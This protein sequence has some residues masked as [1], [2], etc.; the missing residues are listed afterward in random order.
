MWIVEQRNSFL[1][2]SRY[3]A[4]ELTENHALE[5]IV[6]ELE[7]IRRAAMNTEAQPKLGRTL[8]NA[9][10]KKKM[11]RVNHYRSALHSLDQC[12]LDEIDKQQKVMKKNYQ[13]YQL[14][15]IGADALKER[16]A[17]KEDAQV[18][19]RLKRLF[20]KELVFKK[21]HSPTVKQ[22]SPI[23]AKQKDEII[24]ELRQRKE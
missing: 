22:A 15:A 17:G 8:P 5:R 16:L 6:P 20:K 10:R 12:V 24:A 7:S 21:G 13:A 19:S 2:R 1:Q 3:L 11:E 9:E 18:L 23:T 14:E 4:N